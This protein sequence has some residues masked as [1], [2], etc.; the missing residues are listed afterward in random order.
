MKS[1]KTNPGYLSFEIWDFFNS[2]IGGFLVNEKPMFHLKYAAH[3][4][5]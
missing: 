3:F 1:I 5:S 4:T 2:S